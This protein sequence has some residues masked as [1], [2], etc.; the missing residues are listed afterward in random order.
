MFG[1]LRLTIISLASALLLAS[2]TTSTLTSERA[3]WDAYN[4]HDYVAAYNIWRPLAEAG[5]AHAQVNLGVLFRHGEGVS[6]DEAEALKWYRR[7]ADQGDADGQFNTGLIY[8]NGWGVPKNYAEAVKWYRLAAAQGDS[9]S[10]ANLGASYAGGDGV[11]KNYVQAYKWDS[12][13]AD[14]GN[15]TASKNRDEIAR[16]MTE[17]Q[18]AEA[19]RLAAEWKPGAP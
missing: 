15:A 11:P 8:D 19:K 10:L 5:N 4:R 14:R 13:A 17:Q 1:R 9:D 18:I 3:G 12:L 2:C 6:K 7:A 16:L